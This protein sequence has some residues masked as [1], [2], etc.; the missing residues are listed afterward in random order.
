MS[1]IQKEKNIG[2]IR[3][4]EK[5]HTGGQDEGGAGCRRSRMWEEQVKGIAE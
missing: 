3:I 2:R 5:Q 1:R 4:Q